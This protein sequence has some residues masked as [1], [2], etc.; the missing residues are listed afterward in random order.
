MKTDELNV[1][2]GFAQDLKNL[3]ER[4]DIAIVTASHEINELDFYCMN[5]EKYQK[6]FNDIACS[7]VLNPI[8]DIPI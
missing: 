1:L 5:P 2:R 8:V 4:Y 7:N 3:A 6:S